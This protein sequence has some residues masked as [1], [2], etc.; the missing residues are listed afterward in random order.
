MMR[1]EDHP[2]IEGMTDIAFVLR[3]FLK[4]YI[5]DVHYRARVLR[6]SP[7]GALLRMPR[8]A[9]GHANGASSLAIALRG[10]RLHAKI[11]SFGRS[12]DGSGIELIVTWALSPQISEEII[13]AGENGEVLFDTPVKQD[14]TRI[15]VVDATTELRLYLARNPDHVFSI[16]PRKFEELVAAILKDFGLEVE[17]TKA[18]RDGGVDIYA[19][20]KHRLAQFLV[21]VEC[22]RWSREKPVGIDVVQRLYGVQIARH[23]SKSVIV[24]TSSFTEPAVTQCAQYYGLMEL[25]EYTHLKS[26]L[27]DF[28]A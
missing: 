24:T 23:A 3:P 28:Q 20:A 18:T 13:S 9:E 19:R 7:T 26:W 16:A 12:Q 2:V 17:L 22:K 10:E 11:H 5:G 15:I 4:A 6:L 21:L 8:H 25:K 27:T 1:P 14:E